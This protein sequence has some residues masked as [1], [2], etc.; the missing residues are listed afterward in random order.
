MALKLVVFDLDG[1]LLEPAFDFDAIRREIG[2]PPG[3]SILEAMDRFS[4]SE[5]ARANWILERHEAEAARR[6][7]LMPGAGE[8]LDWLR[9]RGIRTAVLTRNSRRSAERACRRHGLAFDAVVT[10]E[11]HLPKPSPEGVCR[12]MQ[13]LGAGPDETIVVGDFSFDVEAGAAAGCR[14]IALV[15][16]PRPTWAS[17][18]TWIAAD[19]AEVRRILKTTVE[20]GGD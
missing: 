6:S 1:T 14:T 7:R 5:R 3:A 2:L 11:D 12:L 8:L 20:R 15:S 17:E 19:L 9:A 18:A 13:A 4:E 16:D 10:R